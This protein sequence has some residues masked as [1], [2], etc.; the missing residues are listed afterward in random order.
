MFCRKCGKENK[1]GQAFCMNCGAPLD[2]DRRN[3]NYNRSAQVNVNSSFSNILE[4]GFSGETLKKVTALLLIIMVGIVLFFIGRICI[5]QYNAE[6]INEYQ[7]SSGLNKIF[8]TD[9]CVYYADETYLYRVYKDTEEFE[10]VINKKVNIIGGSSDGIYFTDLSRD[11]YSVKD[12]KADPE[13]IKNMNEDSGTCDFISG[14]YTYTVSGFNISKLLNSKQRV[15]SDIYVAN[16]DEYIEK[17]VKCGDYIYMMISLRNHGTKNLIRLNTNTL[18]KTELFNSISDFSMT[19]EK[20]ACITDDDSIAFMNI[21]G[22]DQNI[23]KSSELSEISE[24]S[25]IIFRENTVYYCNAWGDW[26]AYNT[27]T[28]YNKALEL[29]GM[30]SNVKAGIN[31]LADAYNG[32]LHLYNSDGEIWMEVPLD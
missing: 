23:I 2:V 13:K 27:E 29:D 17:A 30:N 14:R 32:T 28:Y 15:A 26:Y 6:V 20:I 25:G 24:I 16:D 21:D 22:S 12:D 5:G 8:E 31:I 4:R 10:K 7:L 3:G 18:K 11:V 19:N 9:S 1:P